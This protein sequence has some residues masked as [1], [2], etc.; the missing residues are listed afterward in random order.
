MPS[1]LSLSADE[2]NFVN[3]VTNNKPVTDIQ[4]SYD[5]QYTGNENN[6]VFWLHV[7]NRLNKSNHM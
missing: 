6:R 5:D 7:N 3:L 2:V 4:L 1:K